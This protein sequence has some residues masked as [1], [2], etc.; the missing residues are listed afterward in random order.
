MDGGRGE[1][2]QDIGRSQEGGNRSINTISKKGVWKKVVSKKM[3]GR[4]G[5]DWKGKNSR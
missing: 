5:G 1:K 3:S 4:F 2:E